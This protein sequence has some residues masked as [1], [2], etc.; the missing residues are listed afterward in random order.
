MCSNS[1]PFQPVYHDVRM[2]EIGMKKQTVDIAR[3]TSQIVVTNIERL[4]IYFLAGECVL[5]SV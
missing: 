2:G 1:I 3:V 5:W 4:A